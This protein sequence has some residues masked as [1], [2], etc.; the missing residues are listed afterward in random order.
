VTAESVTLRTPR[1][2]GRGVLVQ[3]WR[4]L[5]F[6]HWPVDPVRVVHLLPPGTRPDT[7]GGVT[8]IGLV[9]FQMYKVR[10]PPEPGV[11]Y[12]R[13]FYETNVRLYSVDDAGRRGVVLV[14]DAPTKAG[15][16]TCLHVPPPLARPR[17]EPDSRHRR[18]A[19]HPPHRAG[20][21]PD[22]EM[23]P[24]RRLVRP[25]PVP[26]KRTRAMAAAPGNPARP[27]RR[28]SRGG[29]SAAAD[30]TTGQRAVLAGRGGPVRNAALGWSHPNR[31]KVPQP[32][33]YSGNKAIVAAHGRVVGERTVAMAALVRLRAVR[34]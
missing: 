30:R 9:P 13:T 14:D 21:L 18:P 11:P 12:F 17:D 8:Y 22:R 10:L 23:G 32:R 28:P 34:K 1:P 4:E 6:L 19:D 25:N 24:A 16:P 33:S 7:L 2:V 31:V 15:R 29:R 27:R 20:T 26:T 3:W 5:T